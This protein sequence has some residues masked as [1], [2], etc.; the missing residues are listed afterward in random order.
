MSEQSWIQMHQDTSEK[1]YQFVNPCTGRFANAVHTARYANDKLT[2]DEG[3]QLAE[4][5]ETL[6][7][8]LAHPATTESIIKQVR[9]VRRVIKENEKRR[10]HGESNG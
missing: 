3:Y 9:E 5:A 8:I 6:W 1:S 4:A 7:Y 2:K 10:Q